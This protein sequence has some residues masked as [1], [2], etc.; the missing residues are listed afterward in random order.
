MSGTGKTKAAGPRER[1][2]SLG[3]LTAL[4][5]TEPWQAALLLPK[6]W[7]DFQAPISRFADEAFSD[8]PRWSY[9]VPSMGNPASAST[10]RR[11]LPAMSRTARETGSGLRSSVIPEPSGRPCRRRV[12][13][14]CCPYDPEQILR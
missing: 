3:R 12:G 5:V 9:A 8:K 6:G 13:R 2:A 1:T 10:V 4:G 7:G 11:A 14:Y